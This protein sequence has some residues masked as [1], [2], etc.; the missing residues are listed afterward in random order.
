MTLPYNIELERPEALYLLGLLP[1]WLALFLVWRI[2]QRKAALSLATPEAMQRLVP[3]RAPGRATLRFILFVLA[4]SL[5]IIALSNPR[6]PAGGGLEARTGIDQVLVLDVSNSMLATDVAPSRLSKAQTLLKGL[7]QARPNDRVA[8]VVFAGHAY[9]Q[10]P[11]TYDH[12]SAELFIETANP[13]QVQGQG[14]AIGESLVQA[15]QVFGNED[16]R[17]RTVLLV[18][19]GETH[20]EEALKS[21]KELADH[22]VMINTIGIGSASGSSIIDPKTKAPKR[23]DAGNVVLS[24][25]NE[26]ILQQIA[27]AGKGIYVHLD[28]L[29]V[30]QRTLLDQLATV[31]NTTLIDKTNLSYQP[32]FAWLLGPMLLLLLVEGFISQRKK[33]R[34]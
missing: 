34:A 8:L 14:T 7:L 10:L 22:G 27:A 2:R 23:D 31:K 18:T 17:Y 29:A 13:G 6:Q 30:A 28:D 16:G 9:A 4:F 21:A 24:K 19:D 25:L 12:G 32:L 33:I 1:L 3:G 11:L 26:A 20:D 15:I 5:G